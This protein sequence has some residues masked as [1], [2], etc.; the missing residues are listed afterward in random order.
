MAKVSGSKRTRAPSSAIAPQPV[1][2]GDGVEAT[3]EAQAAKSGT[4]D[5]FSQAAKGLLA[6]KNSPLVSG[7]MKIFGDSVVLPANLTDEK[8]PQNDPKYLRL[9]SAVL[10]L[11][12]L[13]RHFTTMEETKHQ[14][15]LERKAQKRKVKW[16]KIEKE[17]EE[18][19]RQ[20][21]ERESS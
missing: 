12:E 19:R 7:A 10:G 4:Q 20:K 13:E 6:H 2:A 1:D 18:K 16:A 21:K 5:G 14:E 8:N 11:D 17:K 3:Q 9:L 15:Y